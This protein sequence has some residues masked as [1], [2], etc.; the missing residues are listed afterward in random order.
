VPET[1]PA[2]L[3][4]AL[5]DLQSALSAWK[6]ERVVGAGVLVPAKPL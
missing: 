2:P 5:A 1:I 4:Q 3:R 6:D